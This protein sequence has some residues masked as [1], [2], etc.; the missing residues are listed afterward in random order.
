MACKRYLRTQEAVTGADLDP[1]SGTRL[2]GFDAVG[3]VY[4]VVRREGEQG[5]GDPTPGTLTDRC[6]GG[7]RTW[8]LGDGRA[9]RDLATAT[10]GLT[11][12]VC[13]D[14]FVA[15]FSDIMARAASLSDPYPLSKSPIAATLKVGIGRDDPLGGQTLSIPVP[16]SQRQG[17]IY[18][19]VGNGIAFRADPID[20]VCDPG[21]C[22]LNG[23]LEPSEIEYAAGAEYIP[24]TGD[25]IFISYRTWEPVPCR[26][27]CASGESCGPI[28]CPAVS[29]GG[30]CA[31]DSECWLNYVCD[32][33]TGTCVLDCVE[34]ERVFDCTGQCGLCETL[35]T[36]PPGGGPPVCEANPDL[37]ECNPSGAAPCSPDSPFACDLGFTCDEG[38]CACAPV[39]GCADGFTGDNSPA[40]CEASVECCRRWADGAE[41]CAE[42][43]DAITCEESPPNE[44]CDALALD[45]STPDPVDGLTE[46][47]RATPCEWDDR[48]GCHFAFQTCCGSGEEAY[49]FI[50]REAGTAQVECDPQCVC[51]PPCAEFQRC[52]PDS[53]SGGCTCQGVPP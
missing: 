34:G 5:F 53:Q 44:A 24:R 51:D 52:E 20:G 32:E 16:R 22:S 28:S 27:K 1:F 12:D 45:N 36:N 47:Q 33:G 41:K 30:P 18:D 39:P 3:P 40:T 29:A 2:V 48:R 37:C 26:E 6:N 31:D 9:F 7:P 50:D 43:S 21:Q 42:I 11:Q 46:C 23:V 35:N 4:A 10:G 8:G 49:C 15:F 19:P 14:S 17:F 25:T 13:A 38:T